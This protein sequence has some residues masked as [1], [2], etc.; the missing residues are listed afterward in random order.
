MSSTRSRACVAAALTVAVIALA[1]ASPAAASFG[2][3]AFENSI[4]MNKEGA[5]ATQA[6]SH[7]YAMT[8]TIVFNHHP[9]TQEEEG[10][11]T[12]V[13]EGNPKDLE[14]SLPAGL[15]VN[16]TATAT[17]CTEA[18]LEDQGKCPQGSAVG[19]VVPQTAFLSEADAP[20][21]NM[22]PQP[23]VAGELGFNLQ[24][25]GVVLH[26]VGKVGPGPDY[27]IVAQVA[28]ITE[29]TNFYAAKLTLWGD[30]SAAS[31]DR[32]RGFCF[33]TATT[34]AE[35]EAALKEGSLLEIEPGVFSCPTARTGRPLLTMPGSCTGKPLVATM[36]AYSWQEPN[37]LV[38]P[39]P[40][41]SPAVTGC[42]ELGFSPSITVQPDTATTDSPSGLSV[43]L[44]VP[45]EESAN[46]LAEAN[47]KDAAVTLP[48]GMAISPSAANGLGSC[49][50]EEIGL[51]NVNVPA[52]PDSSKVAEAEVITPLLEHPLKGSVFLAQQGNNPFGSLIALYLVVEGSGVV[53]KIPGEVSLDPTTGQVT[54]T[55]D[56]NPQLPFSEL[57]LTFFGGPRAALVTPP[58]CGTY[59][60]TT[61]LTP[62]SAP[63]SGPPAT[64]SDGFQVNQGCHGPQFAP[65]FTAGTESSRAGAFSPFSLTLSRGD[66]DQQ[67]SDLSTTLPPGLLAKLAGVPLCGEADANAGTCPAASRIGSV[68]VGAG[69]GPDPVY[70]QGSIYLTGSYRGAPF[71]ESV[72]VP[73]IA[74]P[75]NLGTVVVRGAIYVNPSTAQAS[76]VSDPFPTILQGVPL[77]VKTVHVQLDREGFVFNPTSCAQEQFT[78]VLTGVQGASAAVSSPFQA[79]N[80]AT[81]PFKPSF[82]AST[83]GK[84]SKA[85]GASLDVKVASNGGP[86]PG[87]GEANIKSVK[88]DLPKQLP[89]RLTTLQKACLA[90]VFEANPANCPKESDVG[91]ATAVTPV[92]ANPL[93]GP[94]YLV[95]HGGAAFP[96]LEVVLQGEGI[97]LILDGQTNIKNGITSS[98]FRTVPDAPISSF[99]LKLPTGRYSILG[100]YVPGSA[101]YNLCGQTLAM[102]TAITGQNGAVVKQT[103]KIA[104]TGCPK[105]KPKK[106]AKKADRRGARKASSSG[107]GGRI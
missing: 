57:K 90:S 28:N 18:E 99:E 74:G 6:G 80:C 98:T 75:F 17:R 72:V 64:S 43:D 22:V 97:T 40:V 52:C 24:G 26:I 76:V 23:G 82:S 86:Q 47:L 51:S 61:Q 65:S 14:V 102:P 106:K 15:V 104:V 79:A 91:T 2:V 3:E 41:E 67:L 36:T 63:F 89:S 92:L 103:T 73:A 44:K 58:A 66:A 93:S 81:L 34:G 101:N 53:I 62:W 59:T 37:S 30:P 77:Q 27:R 29:W 9:P 10:Q 55:F 94:A 4:T 39:S 107:H 60:T 83:A 12:A 25:F 71:G 105:P 16:P 19:T 45:N 70:V 8:T 1:F 32:E 54:A 48:A 49:T 50:P 84:A 100:A 69:P 46:G 78:G 87:G 21:F 7:P 96:D 42:G 95:S 68:T 13:V 31:H 38:E 11:V 56:D 85:G 20:V 5:P 35:R 33:P 88:V